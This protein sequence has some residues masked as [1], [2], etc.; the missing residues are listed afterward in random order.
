MV[1]HCIIL[2]ALLVAVGVATFASKSAPQD[3]VDPTVEQFKEPWKMLPK[4]YDYDD[5]DDCRRGNPDFQYSVVKVH[6]VQNSSSVLWRQ[7]KTFSS[8][9]RH[10][11]RDI[12]EIGVCLDRCS[13]LPDT[14]SNHPDTVRHAGKC[15][16]E[17]VWRNYQLNSTTETL[18]SISSTHDDQPPDTITRIFNFVILSILMLIVTCTVIHSIDCNYSGSLIVKA[19]SLSENLKKLGSLSS[20]SRQDL[21]IL[22]G[23][24]VLTM[25]IILLCHASIPFIR[26]PLK[27][28]ENM[29]QQFENFWFPIAMAG[30]TYTVQIFFVIGGIVLAVNFMD[31]IKSHPEFRLWY[32]FDRIVNRLI[33]ILPVYSLV[34]LFQV[35]WYQ[36]LKDGPMADRYKDHCSE[37]WWTNLLF[38][39]NYINANEPCL[40]FTW[41][42]GADFQLYLAGTVIMMIVW[43]HISNEIR[44]LGYYLKVYVTFESN[45]GNYF[46][47]MIT[48]IIYHQFIGSGRKLESVKKFHLMFL[49]AA[50]FFISMNTATVF[51]PRDQLNERSMVLASYGSLLKAS[52]GILAS[53]LMFY[54]SFRP[55]NLFAMFLRHPIMLVMSKLTYC[56][57]VVQYTVVYAIYRNV[58]TP[59]TSNAFNRILF[60]SAVLFITLLMGFL[61][62]VCIEVPVMTLFKPIFAPKRTNSV[63]P[64]TTGRLVDDEGMTDAKR[65]IE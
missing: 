61:L 47:G 36:R 54:L 51:L 50:V 59:L 2:I 41:Y 5:F 49:L 40:Q 10:Y 8:D 18:V 26:F 62:H 30:N 44:N 45:A 34:I 39:N 56:A 37:N 35:S 33:R 27:N 23:A 14:N 31:H 15:A 29:E 16:S 9:P 57:Y 17:R 58:T 48:G 28:P 63:V 38:V 43:R 7:I 60:T 1:S 11:R 24:R 6:I 52:W 22:D 55:K 65:I 20:R 53:F 3:V 46:F 64:T 13:T 32:F 12:L 42:L 19:F 25:L 4:L 21:L